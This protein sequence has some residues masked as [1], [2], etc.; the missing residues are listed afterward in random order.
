M[1]GDLNPQI[2][3]TAKD[4]A[5][6]VLRNVGDESENLGN[7]LKK[8]LT[9]NIVG[10]TAAFGAASA[11]VLTSV[12]AFGE[13]QRVSAQ[14][15][16]VL[17]S[18]GGVAGVTREQVLKMSAALQQQSTFSDEAIT[19]AQNLL[20]TF[21]NIGKDV[22]PDATQTVLDMSTALGQDLKSSSIQLGKALNDPI[23]GVTALRRV[24]VSFNEQQLEQIKLMQ[25]SGDLMGAQK[26]VLQELSKEFGGSA[27]AASETFTGQIAR[28]KENLN[29]TQEILGK[30]MVDALTKFS[31]GMGD[32]NDKVI[33]F[34]SFLENN[35]TLVMAVA[36]TLLVL[37]ATFG[38]LLVGALAALAGISLAFVGMIALIVGGLTFAAIVF[39]EQWGAIKEVVSD[40]IGLMWDANESFIGNVKGLWNSLVEN[41]KFLWG[42]IPDFIRKKVLDVI[43]E[44]IT[45]FNPI[46]KIGL[47]LPNLE[48]AWEGLKSRARKL[49]IPGFGAGNATGGIV[50][51]P[52]GSPQMALVHGGEEIVPHGRTHGD[53]GGGGVTINVHVG[54]YAGSEIEKRKIGEELYKAL[55]TLAGTQNKTVSEFFGG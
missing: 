13:S 17:K 48:E 50:P 54:L 55:V 14:L 41:I 40:N 11:A 8:K 53:S 33:A 3:I 21:T 27:L 24:G 36:G 37:L 26:I 9:D 16:A 28:L 47:E 29:N 2:V 23:Q 12:E 15:N 32:A 42:G 34:N 5:T 44:M 49:G 4:E 45:N 18:T 7:T 19:S 22:F 39:R 25:E 43:W 38:L 46:I 52:I 30:G 1:P 35:Q 6:K 10:I 31:G 51:G 20:L